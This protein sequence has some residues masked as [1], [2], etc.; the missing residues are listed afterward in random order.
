MSSTKIFHG[1]RV[2]T[3]QAACAAL[4]TAVVFVA[5]PVRAQR[6]SEETWERRLIRKNIEWSEALDGFA[7]GLDLFL[8][9]KRVTERRN[10]THL[11]VENSTFSEEGKPLHNTTNFNINVQLPNLEDYWQLKFTSYDET[12]E[13]RGVNRGYLRQSPRENNYG[14]SV[15]LFRSFGPVRARFNPR[16][17][18]ADPLRVSHSITLESVAD[19]TT[20]QINPKLEFF[21]NPDKGTGVFGALNLNFVLS[22]VHSLSLV[23]EGEY[24]EREN[25]FTVSNGVSLGR[26]LTEKTSFSYNLFFTSMSRPV[27]HIEGYSFSVVWAHLIYQRILDYQIIPHVDFE[28]INYRATAGLIVNINLNF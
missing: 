26:Q 27:M 9:G 23:N 5:G 8:V 16:L 11:R 17:H 28:T 25:L 24:E 19:M 21:A 18:L 3:L 12:E 13:R 1:K 2:R 7:E 10:E 22:D 4:A 15:G 6:E 20:Y 14:A